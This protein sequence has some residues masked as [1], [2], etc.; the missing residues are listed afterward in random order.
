MVGTLQRE[1]SVDIVYQVG[2]SYVVAVALADLP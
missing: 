2:G 1:T